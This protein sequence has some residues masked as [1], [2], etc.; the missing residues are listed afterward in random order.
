MLVPSHPFSPQSLMAP[1]SSLAPSAEERKKTSLREQVAH[2]PFSDPGPDEHHAR[3]SEQRD[4]DN[5]T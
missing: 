3:A 4:S 1:D 5:A 2:Q